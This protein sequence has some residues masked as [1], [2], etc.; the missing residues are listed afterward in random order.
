MKQLRQQISLDSE[1]ANYF[2]FIKCISY[3][4]CFQQS[5]ISLMSINIPS[6]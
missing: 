3:K 1:T 5:G 2:S 6:S 4:N